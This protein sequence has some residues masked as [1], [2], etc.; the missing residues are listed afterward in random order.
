[1]GTTSTSSVDPIPALADLAAETGC[2]LHVDG[3]YGGSAAIVPEL[4]YL[5]DGVDRADSL[6]VNPHKWLFTPVDC[7]AFWVK[8]RALLKRAF[9]LVADYLVTPEQDTATN[10]MDYGVQLGRRFR[11]LKLW[12]VLRAFGADGLA[13]RLRFHCE[14]ARDF[15]GMVHYDGDWE[16]VAPVPLALVVFRF[17]PDGVAATTLDQWNLE[18]MAVVNASGRSYLS[19]TVLDG[20]VVLRLAVGNLRTERR[21][22][23]QCWQALRTAA[24]AVRGAIG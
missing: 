8:D 1:V 10:F 12:M 5:L 7:T 24:Q 11:S 4:R 20:R 6:V 15:A 13:E 21:H 19:H 9:S 2:W 18:I 16:V 23:E 22:V 3:A 17:A 14:L